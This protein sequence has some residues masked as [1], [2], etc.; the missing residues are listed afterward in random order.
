MSKQDK[1]GEKR[2]LWK[3]IKNTAYLHIVANE[4][5]KKKENCLMEPK[6]EDDNDILSV[7]V[8]FYKYLFGKV[9][10]LDIDLNDNFWKENENVSHKENLVQPFSEEEIDDVV[11][12][13]YAEGPLGMM[14]SHFCSIRNFEKSSFF[15]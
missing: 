10:R 7:A 15:F 6:T 2:V 8:D 13:S 5:R 12:T 3:E 1:D 11:F 9:E 4:R 14:V